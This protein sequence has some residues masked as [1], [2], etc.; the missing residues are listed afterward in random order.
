MNKKETYSSFKHVV[1]MVT[2]IVSWTIFIILML[3]AGL[4]LYYFISTRIYMT[5]GEEYKPAFGLYTIVSP[6]ME[7]NLNIY[8]VIVN[9]NVKSPDDIKVGDVI[10]FVST[11]AISKGMTITHR[12]VAINDGPE[13]KEYTTKG[14]NN[15]SPDGSPA[16]YK[17]VLGKVAFKLPQLGRIQTLLATKGG[18]L[19][20]VVIPAVLIIISDILKLFRLQ[21][22]SKKVNEVSSIE[23]EKNIREA[24]ELEH[25]IV[26]LNK[27]L[28]PQRGIYENDPIKHKAIIVKASNSSVK[29]PL[30]E[31]S[32]KIEEVK[33][34]KKTRRR[35]KRKK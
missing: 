5:K 34:V 35:R 12:V 8:D 27:R 31:Q 29:K 22:V 13:G 25:T 10:T 14:D 11:S 2:T 6:S 19:I 16:L 26:K 4:L 23:E 7:P 30:K 17:N 28:T 3:L 33:T 9:V 24:K 1:K 18:W 20:I 32:E 15:L 21:D